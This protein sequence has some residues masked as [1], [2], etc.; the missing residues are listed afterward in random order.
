MIQAP[1]LPPWAAVLVAI[2]IVSGAAIT[3]IGSFGLIRLKSFYERVHSPTLGAT[4]G[5]GCIVLASIVCFAALGS[6]FVIHEVLILIFVS[7]TTPVTL[8]LLARAAL[9]RDRVGGK[10]D[11]PAPEGN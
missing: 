1:D 7:L 10:E 3:L 11:V 5:A 8:M 4:L 2:L 9:Y 6:R